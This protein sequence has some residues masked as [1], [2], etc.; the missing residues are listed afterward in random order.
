MGTG[1][2][3]SGGINLDVLMEW[4]FHQ[5]VQHYAIDSLGS[6]HAPTDLRTETDGYD[7]PPDLSPVIIPAETQDLL[8]EC[9][10]NYN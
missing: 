10:N 6:V 2:S 3:S 5:V 8:P 4:Y 7:K 1:S 9:C